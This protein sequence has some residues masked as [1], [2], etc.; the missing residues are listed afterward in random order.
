MSPSP[1]IVVLLQVSFDSRFLSPQV[2][3][4]AEEPMTLSSLFPTDQY[5]A[6]VTF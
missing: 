5:R 6:D 4:V 3:A 2:R 1:A